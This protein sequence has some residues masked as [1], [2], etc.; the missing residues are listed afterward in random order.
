MPLVTE[1]SKVFN[2]SLPQKYTTNIEINIQER[3]QGQPI[4][5]SL[6]DSLVVN[7]GG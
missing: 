6:F 7:A 2:K 1:K 3:D 5:K 4:K